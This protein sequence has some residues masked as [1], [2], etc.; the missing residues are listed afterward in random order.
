MAPVPASHE[1]ETVPRLGP[2]IGV[3]IGGSKVLA[4]R[5]GPGG[6]LE[7]TSK[8]PTPAL[9]SD[10]VE[11]VLEAAADLATV[12]GAE[13][14]PLGVGCPGM[15]DQGGKAHFC[16]HLHDLDGFALRDELAR[17][18]P[19]TAT[20]VV[21]N[22]ATAA[23]WAEHRLGAG[24]GVDDLIM[25]TLGTGIGG[26]AVVG[27]RLLEGAHG[28]AGEI[29][30]MVIDPYGP[31]CP[32]GK[33]G[34]WE[35]YASGDGLGW[36]A[37]QAAVAGRLSA[38]VAMAGHVPDAVRGEH[39]SAAARAGDAEAVEVMRELAGWLALGLAN[40]ANL[41][42]P[43]LIVIGGGVIESGEVVMGPLR[44]AFAAAVEG[45]G[46]RGVDIRAAHFGERAGAVGA[47][48]LARRAADG[49]D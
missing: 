12:D 6:E 38:V 30:H 26:G 10:L 8:R 22:D 29:G 20:T 24:R 32:C 28:F 31:P 36:L 33:R 3:D 4:L 40:L 17:Q 34:C 37:R 46:A 2:C 49:E 47:A 48:L 16:P 35:R 42:D 18:R 15:I 23:C 7:G 11:M 5:L 44:A 27:G 9:A 39:V 13:P 41:L 14:I 43:S 45:P 25:V 19:A 21:F 1:I